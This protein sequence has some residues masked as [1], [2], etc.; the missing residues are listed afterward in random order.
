LLFLPFLYTIAQDILNLKENTV[1]KLDNLREEAQKIKKFLQREISPTL[2]RPFFIEMLGT[3]SSGKTGVIKQLDTFF[4]RQ[5]FRVLCPQE[6]AE[7]VRHISRKEPIYNTQTGIYALK[8]LVDLMHSNTYDVVLFDRCI[9]DAC[10]WA[11]YHES[12]GRLTEPERKT[13]QDFFLSRLWSNAIDFACIMTCA[14]DVAVKRE[15]TCALV[16]QVGTHT[17]EET[18]SELVSIHKTIYGILSPAYPQL[19]FM[20]TTF[21]NQQETIER[22]CA[23][24]INALLLK[25]QS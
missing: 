3:P 23:L 5:G 16:T 21:L 15:H 6:G 10:V 4:R 7:V 2:P 17:N 12:K 14:P 19:H 24:V 18:I 1:I 11:Q 9:F 25:T 22:M 20:D 13:L 8:L